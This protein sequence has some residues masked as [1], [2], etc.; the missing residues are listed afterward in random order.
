MSKKQKKLDTN[1]AILDFDAP[2]QQYETLRV[3][4]LT[5]QT[6]D[7]RKI[8]NSF[9]EACIEIAATV[10][11]AL[12]TSGLSREQ[13]V[14]AI[15]A[16][17]HA[18]DK[19]K[20]LSI[21]MFNHYLSKPAEYP[22]PAALIYAIQHVTGSLETISTLAKEAEARVIDKE[23]IRKLAIGKLD[24][25]IAEMQRLKKEFRGIKR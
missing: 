15:N 21:H 17:F 16:Y 4:L 19:T 7:L 9:E 25:A 6:E 8:D 5:P 20:R 18:P 23:E 10:K 14:D 3:K 11:S 13:M 12:R 1:Q 24:D 22:M 2:I